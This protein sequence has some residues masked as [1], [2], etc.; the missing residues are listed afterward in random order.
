[1]KANQIKLKHLITYADCREAV[2]SIENDP[3]NILGGLSAW[4]SGRE[5]FLKSEAKRKIALIESKAKRLP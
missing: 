4:N 5:T 2:E 3:R 1:M